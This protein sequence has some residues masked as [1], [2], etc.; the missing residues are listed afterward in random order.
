MDDDLRI[1][2][3]ALAKPEPSPD[4]VDR[5]RHQLQN[6]MRGGA[7]AAPGRRR[8]LWAVGGT[9]LTAGVAAAAVAIAVA[10]GSVGASP[11][12][13]GPSAHGGTPS[14][15]AA[16]ISARQVFLAAADSASQAPER[17]GR[18]W[19][20]GVVF[21]D[22]QGVVIKDESYDRWFRRDGR[23]YSGGLKT[24]GKPYFNPRQEP[25]FRAGGPVLTFEQ[26]RSLPSEP[27]DLVRRMTGYVE[28]A[29]I[30]TSAGELDARGRRV[31]VLNDLFVLSTQMPVTP[32]VRAAAFRA[33]AQ[34]PEVKSLGR[35]GTGVRLNIPVYNI[36]RG[37][38]VVLDPATGRLR[39]SRDFVDYQGGL[40]SASGGSTVTITAGWTDTLST[41][42]APK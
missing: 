20:L 41:G 7:A 8:V 28:D 37:M 35:V 33:L 11:H 4:T 40:M 38:E 23:H 3:D 39:D 10:T 22:A 9:G 24:G 1:V 42:S 30:R 29:H 18:Y 21:H 32:K 14:Q 27:E 31:E 6:A 19:H 5:R 15:A 12:H 13:G 17:V 26:L 25:G 16:P 36:P 34:A 2:A